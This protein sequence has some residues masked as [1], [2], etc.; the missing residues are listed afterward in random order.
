VRAS[1]K[2]LLLKSLDIERI[3][4]YSDYCPPVE[5]PYSVSR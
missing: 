5:G 3:L 2:I 4:T 1:A